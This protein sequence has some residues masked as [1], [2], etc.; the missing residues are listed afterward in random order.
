MNRGYIKFWRKAQDSVSWNRGLMYQG[1]MINFLNRAAWKKCSYQGRDIL[2]G[3]F[4]AVMSHLAENLGVPRSTLQRMVAHL[5][6]DDFLKVENVGNRFVMITIV[7]WHSYQEY[8][9]DVRATSGQPTGDQRAAGGQPLNKEEEELK[10]EKLIT[11]P[12]SPPRGD[13][14]PPRKKPKPIPY[15]KTAYGENHRVKLTAEELAKLRE[16][17]GDEDTRAA[18]RKL[19]LHI[20]AKGRDVYKSHYAALQSWVFQAVEEDRARLAR[21][22]PAV[23][24]ADR[25]RATT[26]AQ[27]QAQ[28]REQMAMWLLEER[29]KERDSDYGSD[30]TRTSADV[31]SAH[32]IAGALPVGGI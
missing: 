12:V 22:A 18:I 21:A 32:G 2:P 23:L 6:A 3:Q 14:A 13:D 29:R 8:E 28:E 27:K 24:T 25:P 16:R 11:P 7:N 4:A 26:Q 5:E 15:P 31:A 17:Y 9:K 30:E 20:E 19:D 10:K 1:L